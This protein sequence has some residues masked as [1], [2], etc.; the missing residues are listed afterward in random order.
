MSFCSLSKGNF[1][2]IGRLYV[3]VIINK[4]SFEPFICLDL[5]A[6]HLLLVESCV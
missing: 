5:R 2:N 1:L 6:I 4:R 3:C